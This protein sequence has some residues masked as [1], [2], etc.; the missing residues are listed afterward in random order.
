[1]F[2]KDPAFGQ[3]DWETYQFISLGELLVLVSPAV[4]FMQDT[5]QDQQQRAKSYEIDPKTT[6]A[7]IAEE[8]Q[9]D[10]V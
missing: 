1:M 2:M 6:L 4:I 8:Q 10:S 3:A 5:E 9:R 7:R